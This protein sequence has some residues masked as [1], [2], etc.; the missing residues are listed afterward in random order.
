MLALLHRE[1]ILLFHVFLNDICAESREMTEF[2]SALQFT[3]KVCFWKVYPTMHFEPCNC[4]AC[5]KKSSAEY[6]ILSW[7]SFSSMLIFSRILKFS[8]SR[9]YHPMS[10]LATDLE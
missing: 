6:F 5:W 7:R 9:T 8:S 4:C 1:I 10:P 3:N 2:S